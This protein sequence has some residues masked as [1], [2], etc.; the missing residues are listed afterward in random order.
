MLFSPLYTILILVI[1][2]IWVLQQYKTW[3]KFTE[4]NQGTNLFSVKWNQLNFLGNEYSCFHALLSLDKTEIV[5]QTLDGTVYGWCASVAPTICLSR[6]FVIQF[7]LTHFDTEMNPPST[8]IHHVGQSRFLAKLFQRVAEQ[9]L[10]KKQHKYELLSKWKL[11][12][13][14]AN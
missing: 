2:T 5:W 12:L 8:A 9:K 14:R 10:N 6:S 4:F 3:N 7:L 1:E 13:I 11:I